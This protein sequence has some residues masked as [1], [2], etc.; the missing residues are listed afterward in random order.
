MK[1]TR[2]VTLL[3]VLVLAFAST[4]VC[5]GCGKDKKKADK[6]PADN[7][8]VGAMSTE[9]Y[10]S[11]DDAAAA[12]VEN[13]INGKATDATFVSYKKEKDLTQSEIAAL[14]LGDGYSVSEVVSAESGKVTFAENEIQSRAARSSSSSGNKSSRIFI[15]KIGNVYFYY[16]PAFKK[17]EVITKSYISEILDYNKYTNVTIVSTSKVTAQGASATTTVTVKYAENGIYSKTEIKSFGVYQITELVLVPYTNGD[18]S[19]LLAYQ[20]TGESED[21]M[22]SWSSIYVGYNSIR[23]F[24]VA[25]F[26]IDHSY[27]ERADWGFKMSKD[28]MS[29]YLT[30]TMGNI[31]DAYAGEITSGEAKYYTQN[32]KLSSSETKMTMKIQVSNM[33][34]TMTA[35]ATGKYTDFGSTVVTIPDEILAKLAAQD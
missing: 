24:L 29:A 4:F 12:F 8:F 17:G 1:R 19:R 27:F 34:V 16:T 22:S 26:N 15:I 18:V 33:T 32:G 2:I 28:K 6:H 30:D 20:R 25:S 21:E 11:E 31:L 10:E 3:L 5:V 7:S 13:E 14:V 23:D 35:T 9:S